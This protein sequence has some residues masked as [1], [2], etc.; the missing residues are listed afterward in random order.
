MLDVGVSTQELGVG[1]NLVYTSERKQEKRQGGCSA[2]NG[3]SE[4]GRVH[5]VM[6]GKKRTGSFCMR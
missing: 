6:V 5:R 4:Q 2:A 1:H 3:P